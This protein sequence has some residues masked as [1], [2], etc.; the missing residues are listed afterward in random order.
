MKKTRYNPLSIPIF[1]GAMLALAII[2]QLLTRHDESNALEKLK[3]Q[4][5]KPHQAAVDHKK[6]PSL[7]I[8]FNTPQEVTRACVSCHT[9]RA[10]E[11]SRSPH[12]RWD[13]EAFIPGRG[14]VNAGK[15]NLINNFC[16]G[17][18]SNEQSCTKCHAGFGWEDASFD[19]E[20]RDNIDCLICHDISGQYYKASGGA[21]YPDR[22]TDLSLAAQSVDLPKKSN[23]GS[24]HFGGGGGNNVKHGDLEDALYTADRSVDVHMAYDGG[25]LACIACHEADNHQ[26]RGKLYSVSSM[27]RNRMLCESCH[28]EFPHE[29]GI[30][31]DHTSKI[32]CQT[33]HIPEYAKV[34]ATKMYWDWSQAGKLRDGLPYQEEDEDGNHT[35]LSIKGSFRWEKNVQPEYIW[36][37]GTADHYFLGDR[38]DPAE[39]VKINTLNG[40]YSDLSSKIIPVKIHRARQIYDCD[41]KT[42]I[43]PKLYAEEEGHG[44]YWRDFNWH[45]AA[46]MGMDAVDQPYSGNFCFISTEMFWPINHMVSPKEESLTCIDCHT[47]EGSRLA[48]LTDF[49]LPGR[50]SNSIV[51]FFGNLLLIMSMVGVLI[52]ALIRIIAS[53]RRGGE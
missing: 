42:I 27:N 26:M 52:H 37:N 50:D 24:C 25:N 21:G 3:I 41:L 29:Q 46:E 32:A 11:L 43:Q 19:F 4:Y 48:S 7:Q 8:D 18:G 40:E 2:G 47:R 14:I 49:Y 34:N 16:I 17:I 33:C 30:L 13:R 9:E 22:E 39:V 35:Y 23:C 28:G 12:W 51:E 1:I 10:E 31:N 20:N 5:A 15:R 38:V 44:A 53:M 36:F 6:F 45:I